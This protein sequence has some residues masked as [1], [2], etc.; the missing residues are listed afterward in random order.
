VSEGIMYSQDFYNGI[1]GPGVYVV[2]FVSCVALHAVWSG[3][4]GIAINQWRDF[5]AWSEEFEDWWMK[6]LLYVLIVFRAIAVPMILHGLYDTLLKKDLPLLALVVAAASFGYL[7]WL[8]SRLRQ[9]DDQDER[10]AFVSRYIRSRIST[11]PET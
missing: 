9:S 2:R 6:A 1:S 3:S 8:I 11:A 4:V 10:A 5:G 7:A